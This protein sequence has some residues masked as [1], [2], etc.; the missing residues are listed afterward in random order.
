MKKRNML[1][2][3][4]LLLAVTCAALGWTSNYRPIP[5]AP[6]PNPNADLRPP[7]HA[8]NGVVSLS[9]R[10]TNNK[11]L[12]GG[13]G[14]V[15][16]ALTLTADQVIETNPT[17]TPN[18]D[19][20]IVLDR[21]G[22]MEG[23]KITYAKRAVLDLID[24]LSAADRLAIVSYSSDVRRHSF[25]LPADATNKSLLRS[26]VGEIRAGGSTNLGGGL[27]EGLNILTASPRNGRLGKIIL[28]SDGLANQGVTDPG[29]LGR[30]A[31][32]AIAKEFSVSTVGVGSD[33]NEQ[34]MSHL[35]DRGQGNYYYLDNP[36]A[37]AEVFQKEFSQAKAAAATALEIRVPL[38]NGVTL[39][40][41]SGY[42]VELKSGEAVFYPGDLRS[43]A[44]RQLHL[45]F[46]VPTGSEGTIEIKGLSLSYLH[47]DRKYTVALNDAFSVACVPDRREVLAS[48]DKDAWG[49]KV[50]NE[51]YNK[52]REEVALD[53]KNGRK[54]E[55]LKKIE[56]Y[57]VEQQAINDVVG[58]GQ[59]SNNLERGLDDLRQSVTDSFSGSP[60]EAAA[61]QKS[62]SKEVQHKGY[63]I[64]RAK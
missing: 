58:S 44:S 30:M 52:L 31:A 57:R 55:A 26:T 28:I 12:T 46:N 4:G 38:A 1:V 22:S 61:K 41:A 13:P 7:L 62:I 53:I 18:V 9:G 48:Y 32:L 45:T 16:L 3:V 24:N 37:F 11:V 8:K 54:D 20:V 25:L 50:V 15:T 56:F 33:F 2:L 6:N 42:P 63:S 34:L 35:A 10:L 23:Q 39:V 43:G 5:P 29:A 21:S 49:A 64:R 14:L 51:D 17:V 19:L 47:Q 60:E 27:Q 36:S 40:N 59:V